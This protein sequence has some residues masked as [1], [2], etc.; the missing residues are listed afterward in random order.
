MI[1]AGRNQKTFCLFFLTV[2]LIG[3]PHLFCKVSNKQTVES[4]DY[5]KL[6]KSGCLARCPSYIITIKKNGSAEYFG[7]DGVSKLGKYQRVL[8]KSEN[9]IYW[10]YIAKNDIFGYDDRYGQIAEDSQ[11]SYLTIFTEGKEKKIA[12][13]ASSP[14]FLND[15]E[16]QI[17]SIVDTGDW[18]KNK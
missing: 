3:S 8:T 13:G 4:T 2:F 17:L 5:I 1:V 10:D 15:L 7:R 11:T 6:E 12:Y 9:K 16:L 18:Q 14:Q